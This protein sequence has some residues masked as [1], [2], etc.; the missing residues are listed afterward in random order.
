[1]V[2]LSELPDA[3]RRE[4]L[5]RTDL[6]GCAAAN[7]KSALALPEKQIILDALGAHGWSRQDTAKALGI[8]RTTLYKKMKKFGIEFERQLV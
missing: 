3:I 1:V 8:N 5:A 2:A 4:E 6:S 7:L